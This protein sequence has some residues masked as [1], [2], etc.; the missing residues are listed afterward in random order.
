MVVGSL[1]LERILAAFPR[2]LLETLRQV[3]PRG[4]ASRHGAV[5]RTQG[6][7]FR[8]E[9]GTH[10]AKSSSKSERTK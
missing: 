3:S 6:S 9:F 1:P 5:R 4:S 8:V 7:T 10:L 2:S